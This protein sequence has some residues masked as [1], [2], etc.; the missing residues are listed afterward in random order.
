MIAFGVAAGTSEPVRQVLG[1]NIE[2]ESILA[3]APP[4]P[5]G[6]RPTWRG[7]RFSSDDQHMQ[8]ACA[9]RTGRPAGRADAPSAG[10]G[11]LPPAV[12]AP[13]PACSNAQIALIVLAVVPSAATAVIARRVTKVDRCH[14]GES[15]DQEVIMELLS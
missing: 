1:E 9:L 5:T 10:D 14:D 8:T 15:H 4:R 11:R 12:P 6:P 7:H 2:T 3:Q 13:A